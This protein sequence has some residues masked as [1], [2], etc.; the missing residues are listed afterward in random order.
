MKYIWHIVERPITREHNLLFTRSYV[1]ASVIE[2]NVMN[3]VS[4]DFLPKSFLRE[5]E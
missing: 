2:L 1:K 4:C 5:N 3:E